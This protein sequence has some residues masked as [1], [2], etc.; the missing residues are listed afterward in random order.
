MRRELEAK[1]TER[2]LTHM[3]GIP[4]KLTPH[5]YG[6]TVRPLCLDLI[7]PKDPERRRKLPVILWICG[8]AFAVMERCVWLPTLMDYARAGYAVASVD[9]RTAPQDPFPAALEDVR[10]AVRWLRAH[11]DE[12]GF[13][14][15]RIATMGESAG[16]YL[17]S[18]AALG[19]GEYDVGENLDFAGPVQAVVNYYGVSDFGLPG[20]DA[21]CNHQ[22]IDE[23]LGEDLS[24]AR[25]E[26]L[27]CRNLVREDSAP[28]L[29]FHGDRDD[30]VPIE[31]SEALYAAL[32]AK[33][34]PSELC[35][36]HGAGHGDEAFFQPETRAVVMEFLK[37]VM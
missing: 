7:L 5:W 13:D 16:G 21:R 19:G 27:A 10:A 28:M 20:Q 1:V 2:V 37:K 36:L 29:I 6:A 15:G 12:F 35:V 34:V 32:Q 14:P 22:V 30:L 3:A 26:G 18:M 8:G 4:Y 9:Y 23:F 11:A 17:A 25:L 31:G 33:G 24:P